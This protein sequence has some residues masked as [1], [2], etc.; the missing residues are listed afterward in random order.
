METIICETQVGVI[1]II[2]KDNCIHTLKFVNER[3]THNTPQFILDFFMNKPTDII[4]VMDGTAFQKLVWE[5]I[6]KIPYGKTKTYS[7]IAAALNKPKA[8]R[9]VANACGKNKIALFIPC[10][11]VVGKNNIGGYEYGV[12]LKKQLLALEQK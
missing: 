12:G 7:E 5:E 3:I 6:V 11:R 9:A 8:Y 1:K 4:C 2:K 10:H